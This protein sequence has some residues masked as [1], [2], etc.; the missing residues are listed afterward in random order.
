[1]SAGEKWLITG[2][3]GAG[4]S[5][6]LHLLAGD[7]NPTS[8]TINQ[9]PNERVGLLT[10]EVELPDHQRRGPQLLDLWLTAIPVHRPDRCRRYARDQTQIG[11]LGQVNGSGLAN[12]SPGAAR[13]RDDDRNT[14]YREGQEEDTAS[15]LDQRCLDRH[16]ALPRVPFARRGGRQGVKTGPTMCSGIAPLGMSTAFRAQ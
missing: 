14:R 6:L 12:R 9:Q 8:G 2:S 7:L 13:T 1:V 5:A 15:W 3:N 11:V 16:S 10:Q 4:K